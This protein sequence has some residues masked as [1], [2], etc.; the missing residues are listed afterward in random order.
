MIKNKENSSEHVTTVV[1]QE[2]RG[3]GGWPFK[4]CVGLARCVVVTGTLLECHKLWLSL[5]VLQS[6]GN[7]GKVSWGWWVGNKKVRAVAS[8]Q[9]SIGV[10]KS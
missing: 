6:G 3:E 8:L 7:L 1:V 2:R 10:L 5:S 4:C 9:M